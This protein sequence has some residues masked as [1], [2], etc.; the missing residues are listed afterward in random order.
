MIP[1][2]ISGVVVVTGAV[3]GGLLAPPCPPAWCRP[4]AL[5][6]AVSSPE[7]VAGSEPTVVAV[8]RHRRMHAVAVPDPG[9]DRRTS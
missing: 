6:G 3:A 2:T 8:D 9:Q 4:P 5:A 1:R 7:P